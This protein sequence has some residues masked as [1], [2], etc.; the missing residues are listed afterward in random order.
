MSDY[1]LGFAAARREGRPFGIT[2]VCSAHP[3]VLRAALRR[4]RKTGQ[5]VLIE[6]TCNQVNHLGGYTGMTPRDFVDLV[7]RI[8]S[9]EGLDR[10]RVIFG[11]DHL[12]PNPWRQEPA[13]V[14]LAKAK[15]MMKAYVSAGF[16]KLHL[17]TSMA[18]GGEPQPLDDHTIAERAAALCR[19]AEDTVRT[20]G[21]PDPVYIL[22]TEV[23]VPGGADHVLD[24]VEPTTPQAARR[25]I[26]VHREVFEA[27]G[28]G[29]VFDRVIAFVVQPGVEFGSDNVIEYEP[30]RA[31]QLS[32]VL[33]AFPQIVFEAH[34]TDYQSG[35]ALGE[36]VRDGFPILKV[37]PG[38]TFA[39]REAL[40]ALDMI[41]SELV[42]G[43]G[44]RPLMHG[45]EALMVADP[46][47]WSGHYHGDETSLRRQRHYSYSDRIRYYWNRPQARAAVDTLFA[48]LEGRAVPET[49]ARQYLPQ[50]DARRVSVSSVEDI[51][52]AAIDLVLADYDQ[53]VYPSTAAL[54]RQP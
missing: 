22:G 5:P 43:Y 14:A 10:D 11:G 9:E 8:A 12:G 7:E 28:L 21:L 18:C 51:L 42:P 16:T 50:L 41:A 54:E 30:A 47:D 40:Y 34:S 38:L 29:H 2:S 49:L 31:V 46:K 39:Y 24:S 27:A 1:L 20:M 19:V 26:S 45:M 48:V 33:D 6:A 44:Q 53:A 3:T 4:A 32:R 36:L 52:I 35:R 23:P 25:T 17:D 15:D 13:D 37:G